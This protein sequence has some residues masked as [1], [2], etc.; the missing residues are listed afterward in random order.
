MFDFHRVIH[1]I[2]MKK[3]PRTSHL[4]VLEKGKDSLESYRLA[5]YLMHTQV[6]Q[7]HV[8]AIT[9]GMLIKAAEYAFR[10]GG[11][12]KEKLSFSKN[13]EEFLEYYTSLTDEVFLHE[14]Y[15]NSNESTKYIIKNIYERKLLKRGF[16]KNWQNL[17]YE[18]KTEFSKLLESPAREK[19]P[20]IREIETRISEKVN[21]KPYNIILYPLIINVPLYKSPDIYSEGL[22][23][24]ILI[25]MKNGEIRPLDEVSKLTT[26]EYKFDAKLFVFCPPNKI[27]SVREVSEH[28]IKE[29]LNV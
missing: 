8:R 12:S 10:E 4:V 21:T 23:Q 28:V 22:E 14:L 24:K 6:Y 25:K 20:K 15:K 1:T 5:R 16:E 19:F 7:H 3:Y 2:T 18:I 27:E 17:P 11:L 9:D 13:D 29:V 26:R